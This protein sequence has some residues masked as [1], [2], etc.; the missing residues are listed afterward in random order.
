MLI[1]KPGAEFLYNGITYR[2]GDVIIGSDQSEYAGL[3]GAILEICDGDDRETEN[4]TP[5]IY[6][7]FE[8]PVLPADIAK[9]EAMFSDLYGEK[10]EL[11]DICFD[12]V[13]MAPEMI[14]VPGQAKKSIKLYI[15][16][17][18]WAAHGNTGHSSSIFSDPLEARARLNKALGNEIDSGCLS[19]WINTPEY[20]TETSENS[21]E[22]WLDGFH[23]ESHY[24]ISLE[25]RD[26][27]LTPS[28]IGDVGRAYL[29]ASR[30]EDFA[31]QVE[32]W[33]EV[34]G[35]SEKDYQRYL[36]DVRIPNMIDK[37]LSD[38]YW[39]CYWEAVSE[40]AHALLCEYLAR[41]THS[42]T[43]SAEIEP[44]GESK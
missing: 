43:E 36:A 19:D 37:G 41:N 13:I 2:V 24:A 4:D 34:S 18:D 15:L 31:S 35:L 14:I 9:V 25:E 28:I 8:P 33:E 3:I 6:C 26:V 7:S 20:R 40:A 21:Y 32:E 17:E 23:C 1:N 30:Y 42:G 22:G 44:G 27:I 39:E 11:D 10:K 16:S 29:D 5:D 12:M 38:T